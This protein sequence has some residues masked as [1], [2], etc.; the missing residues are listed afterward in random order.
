MGDRG[1]VMIVVGDCR[2]DLTGLGGDVM[3]SMVWLG[4]Q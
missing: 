3:V 4:C 1:S 2:L